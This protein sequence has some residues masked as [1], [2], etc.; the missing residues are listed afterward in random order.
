LHFVQEFR[1]KFWRDVA[2]ALPSGVRARQLAELQRAERWELAL[3]RLIE[4]WTRLKKRAL[5][6]RLPRR[7][8]I[9]SLSSSS[10]A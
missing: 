5:D 8:S 2:A 3:D 9:R 10:S 4:G 6:S 1:T 7:P